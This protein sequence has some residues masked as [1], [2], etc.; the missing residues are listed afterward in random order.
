MVCK[1]RRHSTQRAFATLSKM[2]GAKVPNDRPIDSIDQAVFFLCQSEKSAREGFP[3]WGFDLLLAVM[4]CN[5]RLH[6]YK[7]DTMF[8]PSREAK[9]SLQH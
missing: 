2:A 8:D 7:Q 5:W 3:I 4:W 9:D 6:F 1:T